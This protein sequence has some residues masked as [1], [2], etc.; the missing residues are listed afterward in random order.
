MKNLTVTP[1]NF[2]QIIPSLSD[3]QQAELIFQQYKNP[4]GPWV[5]EPS[6]VYQT[7]W[8]FNEPHPDGLED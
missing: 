4:T 2:D 3:V 8:I 5:I 1:Q 6:Y 7:T